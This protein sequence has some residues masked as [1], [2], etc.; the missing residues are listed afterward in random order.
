MPTIIGNI[1]KYFSDRKKNQEIKEAGAEMSSVFRFKYRIFK[2]LL[3]ANSELL[4]LLSDVEE[5]LKGDKDFG[6]IYI[7]NQTQ[8]ALMQAF[9]MVK[10]INVLSNEAYMELYGVL[11][12]INGRIK[13]AL[14]ERKSTA[15]GAYIMDYSALNR[16]DSDLVGG[17]NANL[18][19]LKNK[20]GMPVPQG[21][22]ITTRTFDEFLAQTNLKDEIIRKRNLIYVDDITQLTGLCR[23]VTDLIESQPLPDALS[24]E[25]LTAYDRTFG[26]DS[27][28]R[29]AMRSSAIGEDGDISF[30]GQ[31]LTLLNV[32][33]EGL[34]RAYASVAA[35]LYTVRSVTY[36]KSKGIY[37][38]DLAMAVACIQM[39]DPVA[40]GVMY[41]RHP[42]DLTNEDIL[43]NGVWGLGTYAVDGVVT[44]DRYSV[45]K[46]DS[47]TLLSKIIAEKSIKQ[48]CLEKGG[49]G[50]TRV[51]MDMQNQPCLTDGQVRTLAGYGRA[52]EAHYKEP[53]DVEWAVDHQGKVLILQSRP[54]NI[55]QNLLSQKAKAD[56]V[57]GYRLLIDQA[58][59]ACPGLG[60][61]PAVHVSSGEDLTHFPKGGILIARHSSP[62]FV[63]AMSACN[64]IVVES[65]SVSGHMAAVSREMNV[66]TLIGGK[67]I[68]ALLRPG[69]DL[70]VDAYTGR[71]YEGLV[72]ELIA[73]EQKQEP[74]MKGTPAHGTLKK[75]AELMNPLHL[76][77]PR[78]PRFKPTGCRTLHD[79]ARFCH[80]KSY[81]EMFKVSDLASKGH[82]WS[83]RLDAPLPMDLHLID[84]GGG[85]LNSL[86]NGENRIKPDRIISVPFLALLSGMLNKDVAALE[87][88]PIDLSGFF[89]VMR[90]QVLS[91]GHVGERFG[92]RSYAIIADKYLNF[93]SRVGYHYSV[94]DAYCGQ[95]IN[96]NYVSFSFKGGAA[97]KTRRIRRVKAIALILTREGFVVDMKADKVDARI[98]K[99]PCSY[100]ESRLDVLGRLLIFTRQMDM[101]MASDASV[102]WVADNFLAGNYG[103]KKPVPSVNGAGQDKSG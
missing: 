90:E 61:G 12:S 14:N 41:T 32:D 49:I 2:E 52:I 68:M 88:R 3:A 53:Q 92:D 60:K 80:E 79:I 48:V 46:D 62:E 36:R 98:Q 89:S 93:S 17:K 66:P 9:L 6:A 54:L 44:P 34:C 13:T 101:L 94:V 42:Y 22:A 63:V 76:V 11:E 84:L 23:E 91:P 96:K 4:T 82:G 73:A 29:V 103:L 72:N 45:S 25:I 8:K 50:E 15:P 30:A 28:V 7:K 18:G 35:S 16:Y 19:E 99:Y 37:D 59:I 81:G 21:F 10:N 77:N 64:G 87:P 58:D 85:L 47:L 43:I 55:K 95:T 20:L 51:A 57:S 71:V 97:D 1:K 56:A 38:E 100:I 78:S 27:G 74:H 75:V 39:V 70:T 33:R 102:E 31:Y 40:S 69:M 5:K 86:P 26:K 83:Y 24:R 67:N 65:G